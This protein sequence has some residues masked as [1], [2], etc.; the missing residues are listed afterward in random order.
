L[1]RATHESVSETAT[2][3]TAHIQQSLSLLMMTV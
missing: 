1:D 3:Q 2:L